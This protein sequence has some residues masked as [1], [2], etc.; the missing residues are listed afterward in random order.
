M[1]RTTALA[2]ATLVAV[3]AV[4]GAHGTNDRYNDRYGYQSERIEHGRQNG[5]ITWREGLKLRKEQRHIYHAQQRFYSDGYLSRYER[6][7]L[8]SLRRS[9]NRHIAYEAHDSWR[10]KWWLPRVGR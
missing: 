6:L 2:L 10:R 7:R 1:I 9:A 8:Q 5:S 4:A 3:P